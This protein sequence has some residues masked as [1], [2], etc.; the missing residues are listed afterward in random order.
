MS[1]ATRINNRKAAQR[2]GVAPET[3]R[4]WRWEGRGPRFIRYGD[5]PGARC[6]YDTDDLDAYLAKRTVTTTED[7]Q[8]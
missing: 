4:K 5:G 8:P 6:Y 1:Q 3:L 2:L 7:A